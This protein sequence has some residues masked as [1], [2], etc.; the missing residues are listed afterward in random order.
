[1]AS[2]TLLV[3]NLDS[4]IWIKARGKAVAENLIIGHVI[5]DLLKMW[6]DGK[7]RIGKTKR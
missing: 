2:K 5:S 7:V 1:M 3:R 6:I 4:D